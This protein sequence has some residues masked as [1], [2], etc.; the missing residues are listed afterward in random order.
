[1]PTARRHNGHKLAVDCQTFRYRQQFRSGHHV[2]RC[3]GISAP[4]KCDATQTA[5]GVPLN[6]MGHSLFISHASLDKVVA[7]E[8]MDDVIR[9]ALHGPVVA[10]TRNLPMRA[11]VDEPQV[12]VAQPKSGRARR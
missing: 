5:G 9:L 6:R 12:R 10:P 8:R 7:I 11:E 4:Q 2:A 1:M 3:L